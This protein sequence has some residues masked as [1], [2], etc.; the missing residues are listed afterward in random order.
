MEVT[1]LKEID[2]VLQKQC[3]IIHCDSEKAI[4]IYLTKIL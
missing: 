4:I 2:N 1:V 3:G